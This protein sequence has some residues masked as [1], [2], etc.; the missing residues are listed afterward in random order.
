MDNLGQAVL[1]MVLGMG[2]VYLFLT[3]QALITVLLTRLA[4]ADEVPTSTQEAWPLST[5]DARQVAAQ[6][7]M[8][9]PAHA[10]AAAS[11]HGSTVAI[12]QAAI[13]A[14]ESDQGVR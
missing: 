12:I 10:L 14:Y 4:P 13:A 8:P 9:S 5:A 7:P 3:V 6:G 1:I 11:S 2:G